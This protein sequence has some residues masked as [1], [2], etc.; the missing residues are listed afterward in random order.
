[1][2]YIA[3]SILKH[4][5]KEQHTIISYDI[6]CQWSKNFLVRLEAL[7]E[8]IRPSFRKWFL[9]FVVPKLHIRGHTLDCQG[10]FS[11]NYLVGSGM[12]DGEG[13]ERPWANLGGIA[14]STREMGPGAR[15]ET[16]D[17]HFSFW[18]WQKLIGC[19][20]LTIPQMRTIN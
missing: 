20:E 13:V 3:A 14:S 18:N 16:L 10:E 4:H 8:Q 15:H 19:G 9:E 12:T 7:P 2:D 17:D 11:L 1:M 5:D 6:A